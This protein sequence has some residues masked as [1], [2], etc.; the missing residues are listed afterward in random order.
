MIKNIYV[1]DVT[2]QEVEIDRVPASRKWSKDSLYLLFL[3][4]WA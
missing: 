3:F 1:L 2:Y 4:F